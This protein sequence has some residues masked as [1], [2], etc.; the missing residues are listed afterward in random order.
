MRN[1]FDFRFIVSC[2]PVNASIAGRSSSSALAC[3]AWT[4]FSDSTPPNP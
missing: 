1:L 4:L 2:P 3:S